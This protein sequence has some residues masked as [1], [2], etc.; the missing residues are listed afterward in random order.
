MSL[1]VE[2]VQVTPF[3]QNCSIIWCD[4][5]LKGAV[6]DPGGDL[7]KVNAV[8]EKH[9]VNIEKILLTH[10]HLDHAGGAAALSRQLSV[11]VIGPHHE[12]EFW[13]QGMERQAENYGFP[14]VEVCNPDQWLTE[15]EKI[16][17]GNESLDVLH[18]PGH[19]PGHI[20]FSHA[21]SKLAFVGDVIFK[22]SIGRTDFPRGD[23]DTLINSITEKLWPLGSDV[24]FVSGHGPISDF[25]TERATNPFVGDSRLA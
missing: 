13:L 23:L 18:C 9:Q 20:I 5:T 2:V 14:G 7:D 19:T 8:I 16:S 25:G 3:Q 12:D 11:P 10:G 15:G 21:D 1:R 22:G 24:R 4:Q 17:I 6:V